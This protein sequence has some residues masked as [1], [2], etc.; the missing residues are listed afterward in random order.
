MDENASTCMSGAVVVAA[1]LAT[2]LS[3]SDG[4]TMWSVGGWTVSAA[5]LVFWW[6]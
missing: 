3:E 4:C 2:S 6:V 5:R 1:V